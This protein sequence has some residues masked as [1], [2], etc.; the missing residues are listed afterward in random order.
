MFVDRRDIRRVMRPTLFV[1]A[2]AWL[3]LLTRPGLMAAHVHRWSAL[4]ASLAPLAAGWLLM[5]A[6]MMAPVLIS[7]V[8]YLCSRS[9]A[10]RRGR[11][12][13]L[14]LAGYVA[15]WFVAAAPLFTIEM[16][17]MSW[18]LG[19][20]LT[21]VVFAAV[22][23]VWQCSPA[24]QICLN[25]CHANREIAAFGAAAD[26][27]AIRF[28]LEHGFWCA[29]ACW[30]LMLLPMLLHQA[31]LPAMA[32]VT[33]IVF[34]ERVERPAFPSWRWRGPGALINLASAEMRIRL[35]AVRSRHHATTV[36]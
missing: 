23:V 15:V 22:A 8:C 20:D 33:A 10:D 18:P 9:F 34:S 26:R 14:F 4:G 19:M 27:S 25:R 28:G 36:P 11:T 5:L 17:S 12:V 13:A 1:S 21:F 2:L 6:A 32:V 24:K 16:A 30:A 31:H 35:H 7:P 29:G 3:A